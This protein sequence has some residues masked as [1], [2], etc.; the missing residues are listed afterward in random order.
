LP[1]LHALHSLPPLPPPAEAGLTRQR[2]ESYDRAIRTDPEFFP[3]K[4]EALIGEMNNYLKILKAVSDVA[5]LT[6]R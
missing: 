2:L 5:A 4:K 6:W 1:C 3:D